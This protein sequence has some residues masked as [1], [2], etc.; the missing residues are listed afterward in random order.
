MVL[1]LAFL[2][3][4][5]IPSRF[6]YTLTQSVD[7]WLFFIVE[8]QPAQ[9]EKGDYV[10]IDFDT[11]IYPDKSLPPRAIKRVACRGGQFLEN[12]GNEYFCAG[13]Y[14]GRAKDYTMNGTP[15][16]KFIFS[17]AIPKGHV[18]VIGSHPDSY[19]SRYFGLIAPHQVMAKVW[20]M[21]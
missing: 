18:F 21:I 7:Y 2:G 20:G 17:G 9:V 19:D 1:C 3:G 10:L 13:Q 4:W 8:R 11:S 15:T 5:N 16:N 12:R 14:L 6:A